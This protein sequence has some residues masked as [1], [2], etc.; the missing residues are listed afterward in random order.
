MEQKIKA[1]EI[2]RATKEIVVGTEVLYRLIKID[3][4]SV[5]YLLNVSSG[6]ETVALVAGYEEKEAFA[7][8][9]LMARETVTPCTANDIY[10]D[11][12]NK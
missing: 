1:R 6:D 11:M 7:F 2:W 10:A 3:A 9:T 4:P 12:L 5:I 8:A